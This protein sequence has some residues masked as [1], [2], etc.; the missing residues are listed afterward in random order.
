MSLNPACST[1]LL[2]MLAAVYNNAQTLNLQRFIYLV[3]RQ[4]RRARHQV[5][6][7]RVQGTLLLS[8]LRASPAWHLIIASPWQPFVPIHPRRKLL[9]TAF[10]AAPEQPAAI[11]RPLQG[12]A[13]GVVPTANAVYCL[14]TILKD[15]MEQLNSAQLVH[16]IEVPPEVV[17]AGGEGTSP[18][19]AKAH[20]AT[21]APAAEPGAGGS[22]GGASPAGSSAAGSPG[23]AEFAQLHN[24]SLV[25]TL[26]R[27]TM[28]TLGDARLL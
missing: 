2:L 15:L 23:H 16:F 27:E 9:H 14:R 6:A 18:S 24:G 25:H 26:V 20:D 4:L 22:E 10:G 5:C 28:L 7:V 21:A 17:A 11:V 13:A 19:E 1:P 8:A 3:A 12:G